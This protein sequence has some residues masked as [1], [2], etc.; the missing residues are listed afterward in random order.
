MWQTFLDGLSVLNE[1]WPV[2]LGSVIVIGLGCSISLFFAP[3]ASKEKIRWQSTLLLVF[4]FA[5]SVVLRLAFITRTF[6]PPYFDSV[7]HFSIIKGLVNALE[8]STLIKTIPTLTPSY[9]HLGFHL[10]AAF[11]T[12][13]LHASPMDVILVLGQI[14]LAAIPIPMF[15]IL[16]HKTHND[17][18]AF[19]GTFLA[20]F[21]WYMPGFAVNWGKYPALAGLLT[22]EVVVSMA[23]FMFQNKSYRNQLVRIGIL[24]LGII[25]STLFHSRTLVVIA[26]FLIS[27]FIAGTIQTLPKAFQYVSL[28]ILLAGL[29][30][31]GILIQREPLLA[32]ALEPYL[33]DGF[34]I[35]LI[36]VVLSP[37]ALIQFSRGF[38]FS[39]LFTLFIF[40][41]LFIPT[42]NLIPGFENQTLLDRPFV[43][44]EQLFFVEFYRK[45]QN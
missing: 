12:F 39:I 24:L 26:F 32:L 22:L 11:L 5:V 29:I 20:G 45:N 37:F 4:F 21:G 14:I 3:G 19:F 44:M 38:Y 36:V 28:G 6:V 1:K 9:Y 41:A 7:E 30:I 23:Y 13:G 40:I 8:S 25:V 27:W 42:G 10:L 35:T 18:A 17:S 15:F 31:V 43:E 16:R 33:R 2:V 34:W